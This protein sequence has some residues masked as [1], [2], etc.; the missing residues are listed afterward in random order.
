MSPAAGT[1]ARS[2][3]SSWVVS[4]FLVSLALWIGATVFLSGGVLP[5]LF[6]NLEPHDAGRIAALIFP[7]YFRAGLVAGVIATAA[8]AVLARD[9][10]R[11]WKAVLLVLVVMTVA[12]A[13][14]TIVVLPEIAR[15]RGME[16]EVE[17]FQQLHRLSVRLNGV[18]LVGGVLLLASGGFLL[19]RRRDES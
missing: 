17:R 6:L 8:A 4:I 3:I 14:S 18:V 5:V 16:S 9:G 12:Q 15:I 11:R 7:I 1:P 13:W 10:G 19:T 2:S